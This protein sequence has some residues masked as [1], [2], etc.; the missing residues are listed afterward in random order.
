VIDL[1]WTMPPKIRLSAFALGLT[2]IGGDGQ[3]LPGC[4]KKGERRCRDCRQK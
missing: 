1:G 2:R 4:R 3:G